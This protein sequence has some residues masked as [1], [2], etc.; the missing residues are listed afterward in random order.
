MNG[1][2]LATL[3]VLT[4]SFSQTSVAAVQSTAIPAWRK[5]EKVAVLPITGPIDQVTAT[6][7]K[8]RIDKAV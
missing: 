8:R 4:A 2:L 1:L 7:L 5:A 3:A 6:S